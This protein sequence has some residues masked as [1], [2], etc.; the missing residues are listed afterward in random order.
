MYRLLYKYKHALQSNKVYSSEILLTLY[1]I[2]TFNKPNWTAFNIIR[3][4]ASNIMTDAALQVS[5]K[6]D[7]D[8]VSANMLLS[9]LLLLGS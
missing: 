4:E 2:S 5:V 9:S 6:Y 8:L 7:N 3:K 1:S